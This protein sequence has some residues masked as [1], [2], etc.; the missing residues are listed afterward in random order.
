MLASFYD[1]F[2]IIFGIILTS[3]WDPPG[4]HFRVLWGSSV[5]H[6]F[7]GFSSFSALFLALSALQAGCPLGG[8]LRKPNDQPPA[9]ERGSAA[10]AP[11]LGPPTPACGVC[12]HARNSGLP[13]FRQER[14]L[15]AAPLL[16][17]PTS[18]FAFGHPIHF[19][20]RFNRWIQCL[21]RFGFDFCSILAP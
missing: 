18:F 11:P 15:R 2:G 10:G 9:S 12:R 1:N 4:L 14:L 8:R 21:L 7:S 16:P 3:C 19:K 17:A 20:N 13:A 5:G 6:R